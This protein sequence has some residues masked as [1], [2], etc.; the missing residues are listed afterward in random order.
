[1][2]IFKK[3]ISTGA[4]LICTKIDGN[5]I[6]TRRVLDPLLWLLVE[7]VYIKTLKN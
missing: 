1:M 3:S 6:R 5:G 7:N 4:N 2:N